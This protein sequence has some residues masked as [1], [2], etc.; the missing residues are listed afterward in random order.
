MVADW[1][2]SLL[3]AVA[4]NIVA[5]LIMPKP[6]TTKPEAAAD[7]DSPTAEEGQPIP[8]VFGTVIVKGVQV[9]DFFDKSKTE[10]EID[11]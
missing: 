10:R 11:A 9:L 4:V 5:Y 6:K 7:L 3:I 8:K 1:I 2:I